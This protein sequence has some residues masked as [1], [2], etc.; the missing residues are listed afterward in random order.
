MINSY[1]TDM[2]P[3]YFDPLPEPQKITVTGIDVPTRDLLILILRI[4]AAQLAVAL[5]FGV[6]VYLL[7]TMLKEG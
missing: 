4:N 1:E 6:P 5:L 7:I 2:K 3:A